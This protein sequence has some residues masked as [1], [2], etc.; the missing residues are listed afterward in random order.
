MASWMMT[1]GLPE[2]RAETMPLPHPCRLGEL[3]DQ[4]KQAD[5]LNKGGQPSKRTGATLEPVLPTLAQAGIDKKLSSRANF[6][7]LDANG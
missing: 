4:Q 2:N 6:D 3:I 1:V 7:L 5:G